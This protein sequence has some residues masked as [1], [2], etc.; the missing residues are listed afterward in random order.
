MFN[1]EDFFEAIRTADL[2]SVERFLTMPDFEINVQDTHG[3][4]PLLMA[5]FEHRDTVKRLF[6]GVALETA[7]LKN[8][9]KIYQTYL[10]GTN[11]LL[12]DGVGFL[13]TVYYQQVEIV[14]RLLA[15]PGV[16][17]NLQD[18]YG[19]TPLFCAAEYNA[20]E[21]V[22]LLL[23]APGIDVNLQ[24]NNEDTP[25][26]TAV[27]Y[28]RP[29]VVMLL[30]APGIDVNA[31]D[32]A[33][34]TALSLAVYYNHPEIV[35]MLLSVTGIDV[36]LQNQDGETP[37]SIA[38]DQKSDAILTLLNDHAALH[39]IEKTVV[40]KTDFFNAVQ[41]EN[42][43]CVEQYLQQ[44]G[45]DVN[46]Q[47]EEGKKTALQFAAKYEYNDLLDVLLSYE[48]NVNHQDALGMTALHY[49]VRRGTIHA[50]EALLAHAAD[51]NLKDNGGET[52]LYRAAKL[53][54][55]EIFKILFVVPGVQKTNI[56]QYALASFFCTEFRGDQ[57]IREFM[58]RENLR[59]NQLPDSGVP[60]P[61]AEDLFK[62]AKTGDTAQLKVLL[63]KPGVDI[64]VKDEE[65]NTALILAANFGDVQSTR[66]LLAH[67]AAVNVKN[68]VGNTAL[69][70][71][72]T[73][74]DTL[75]RLLLEHGADVN[76]QN[77]EKEAVLHFCAK[78]P[79][80]ATLSIVLEHQP[81]VNVKNKDGMTPLYLAVQWLHPKNVQL[82]LT[83]SGVL[84]QDIGP[85]PVLSLCEGQG[86]CAVKIRS[87]LEKKQ[88]MEAVTDTVLLPGA[89]TVI[90]KM[91]QEA[92][93]E[94]VV[95]GK[96]GEVAHYIEQKGHAIV[97]CQDEHGSTPLWWA[98]VKKNI[99]MVK[100]LLAVPGVDVN[101]K[102]N[103]D[104]T[105][106]STAMHNRCSEILLLLER[107]ENPSDV[108]S[109][110]VFFTAAQEGNLA[111]VKRYLEQDG[112]D[113]NV[114]DKFR[115][116]A[117]HYACICLQYDMVMLLLLEHKADV[118]IAS[119]AT[120][121]SAATYVVT[122]GQVE[123]LYLMI[124]AGMDVNTQDKDGDTLLHYAVRSR[125]VNM[126]TMLLE[127]GAIPDLYNHKKETA[128][129]LCNQ[130]AQYF[131]LLLDAAMDVN[132]Q[133]AQGETVLH[134]AVRWKTIEA[135][136]ALL[137]KG[138][139]LNLKNEK[140]E[141]ALYLAAERHSLPIVKILLGQVGI[142]VH[143][144]GAK[145]LWTFFEG[146]SAEDLEIRD[147]LRVKGCYKPEASMPVLSLS[148]A[149]VLL[150]ADLQ[151]PI[152]VPASDRGEVVEA[153]MSPTPKNG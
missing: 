86:S 43:A 2:E 32:G 106:R 83:A 105:P 153:P 146:S 1:K 71:A 150:S 41:A 126:V 65:G 74:S 14:K 8:Y 45:A 123:Y 151:R 120:G 33:G 40:S 84:M 70:R 39:A 129:Y 63:D 100:L 21:V 6:T 35:K 4:S 132:L 67:G 49:A 134:Q 58:A 15:A 107:H 89:S 94:A 144:I 42:I 145:P 101:H 48:P 72:C 50:V 38:T 90:S 116:T 152:A 62:A 97:N 25:L 122:N 91:T 125:K 102:D 140:G 64:N 139:D 75:V 12:K 3:R 46:A 29:E 69:H 87:L 114:Q 131:T 136:W 22:K 66:L 28:D 52:A 142:A 13:K 53:G 24:N 108:I 138:I 135:L 20:V 115:V 27:Y 82:L 110:A 118:F 5:I 133:N 11:K 109:A 93:F 7:F 36:N 113:V 16:D 78:Y 57:E 23:A 104:R 68:S 112:V 76:A 80:E 77:D 137:Q 34:D 61:S 56:G 98:V 73:H 9:P 124:L 127:N 81:D 51:V 60:A 47:E 55:R 59:V 79:I 88:K 18:D 143:A 10:E 95:A 99:K 117:V 149:A 111:M 37:R 148:S 85:A 130:N 103:H 141:T 54:R 147:L 19:C 26:L 128:L 31:Q 92:F 30:A 119:S 96:E 44:D 17:V 121:Y